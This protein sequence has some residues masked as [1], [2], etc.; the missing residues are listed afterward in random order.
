MPNK[1]AASDV[2]KLS[3]FVQKRP[4]KSSYLHHAAEQGVINPSATGN[5]MVAGALRSRERK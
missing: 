4:H 1:I 3:S 5:A 2:A